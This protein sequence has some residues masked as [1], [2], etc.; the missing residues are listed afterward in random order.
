[1]GLGIWGKGDLVMSAVIRAEADFPTTGFGVLVSG[2]DVV[3]LY[4][5][6][7][8]AVERARELGLTEGCHIVQVRFDLAF[9]M[10]NMPGHVPR[11]G[12][13]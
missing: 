12:K 6:R 9:G 3:T 11:V 7:E 2:V 5:T 10:K 1:M 4:R 13:P 8:Q